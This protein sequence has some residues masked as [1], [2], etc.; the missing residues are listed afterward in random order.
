VA[1]S[2]RRLN[3][4]TRVVKVNIK[5]AMK[6][7][8]ERFFDWHR[9]RK[10]SERTIQHHRKTFVHLDRWLTAAQKPRIIG[11]LNSGSLEAFSRW[12]DET[13]I[14]GVWRGST[15]RSITGLHGRM[16]DMRA[17]VRWAVAQ[18]LLPPG[19][20]V[21]MPK[22]P[23]QQFE[24]LSNDD[25]VKILSCKYLTATG[26]QG[27]RNRALIGLVLDSA[28][29]LG[30][31]LTLTPD[32][33]F[34]SDRLARVTGRGSKTRHVPFSA[35]TAEAL[36][37]WLDIRPAEFATLFDLTQNGTRSLFKL[38]SV[39]LAYGSGFTSCATKEPQ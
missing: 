18:Q 21:V 35:G 13:P 36:A 16:K 29:R 24:I 26:A 15:K 10:H 12:L 34:V 11:V 5:L 19:V 28:I 22:L 20:E 1:S 38:S 6:D 8:Q 33:I 37:E 14:R 39:K 3:L 7:A 32:Q 27:V 9:A 4:T 31:V 23:E 30:E 2:K 17:F 25:L